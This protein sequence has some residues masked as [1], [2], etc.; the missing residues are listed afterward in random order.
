MQGGARLWYFE[1]NLDSTREDC[2]TNC[3]W[4][5]WPYADV[6]PCDYQTG[7]KLEEYV[8]EF[9]E[10]CT[11]LKHYRPSPRKRTASEN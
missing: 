11:D 5:K 2:E 10:Q 3:Y 4:Y 8:N 1:L 9:M 7:E 6:S